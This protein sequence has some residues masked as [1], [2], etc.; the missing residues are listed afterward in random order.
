VASD[1]ALQLLTETPFCQPP[2]DYR[3]IAASLT[4]S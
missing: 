2:G 4:G 1:S 3:L